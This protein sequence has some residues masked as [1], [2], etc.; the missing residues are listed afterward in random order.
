MQQALGRLGVEPVVA[1]RLG[2]EDYLRTFANAELIIG[3]HGAGITNAV[4]SAEARVVEIT[5]PGYPDWRSLRLFIETGMGAPFRRVVMPAPENGVARYDVAAIVA[6]AEALLGDPLPAARPSP[7][8]AR[9]RFPTPLEAR[10][11]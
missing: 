4:L 9:P 8:S 7:I 2:V 5:V 6:A 10:R 1:S 11:D 3:L